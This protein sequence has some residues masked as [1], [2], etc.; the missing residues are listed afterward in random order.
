MK[1]VSEFKNE[2]ELQNDLA[3]H[4]RNSG[5]LSFTE[6]QIPN[7]NGSRADIIAMTPHRYTTKDIRL[8]EVKLT[9]GVWLSDKKFQKYLECC[10]R[11]YIACPQG[12]IKKNE[13]PAEIGLITRSDK[14]WRVAKSPRLNIKPSKLDVDFVL[15]LLYRGYE[16]TKVQRD[17]RD[18]AISESNYK[19]RDVAYQIGFDIGRR[20]DKTKDAKIEKWCD[21]LWEAFKKHGFEPDEYDRDA[22][23]SIWQLENLLGGASALIKDVATIKAIGTYLENIELPEEQEGKF[24]W[25][26]RKDNREKALNL[27]EGK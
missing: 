23:P 8:Y 15:S 11:M 4:L 1:K 2:R 22:L 21:E 6:I 3:E 25:R 10:N 16:E 9:R 7:M 14:G 18:R 27:I 19:L 24:V 12:V 13:L 26:N 5:L 20:L 17:L